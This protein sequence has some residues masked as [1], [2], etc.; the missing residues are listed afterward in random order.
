[1]VAMIV[2]AA[3]LGRKNR[4]QDTKKQNAVLIW[5]ALLIDGFELIKIGLA[6]YENAVTGKAKKIAPL[7]YVLALLFVLKYI[8]L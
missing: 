7:M 4:G 3:W 6:C 1:M 5:A 8:F 2:L